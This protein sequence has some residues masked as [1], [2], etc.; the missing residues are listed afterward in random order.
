MTTI[1]KKK[2]KQPILDTKR[3]SL[4][5]IDPNNII[6]EKNFNEREDYGNLQELADSIKRLGQ[7]EPARGYKKHGEEKFILTD[8]HRRL[9]AIKL[10]IKQGAKIP[11]LALVH[12][13]KNPVDRLYEMAITGLGKKPLEP[14]EEARIYSRLKNAGEKVEEI[15]IKSGKSLPHIY[16]RIQLLDLDSE[17][18][19]MISKNEVSPTTALHVIRQ[20][21]D[22]KEAYN[23]IKTI[24]RASKTG[25]KITNKNVSGVFGKTTI[26]KLEETLRILSSEVVNNKRVSLLNSMVVVLRNSKSTAN[27]VAELFR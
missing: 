16:S 8:G 23:K 5:L 12:G 14:M 6:V 21:P 13:S 25:K 18:Q 2:K 3:G 26:Q 24:V 11:Y 19:T 7:L 15:A 17:I 4:M 1:T 27:D 9:A 22:R 20:Y 10:A